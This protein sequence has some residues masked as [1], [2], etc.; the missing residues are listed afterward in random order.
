MSVGIQ[1]I[2]AILDTS[3]VIPQRPNT[4]PPPPFLGEITFEHVAFAYDPA[5][6]VLGDVGFA[7]PQ[8]NWSVSSGRPA[9]AKPL[10]H[11][12]SP[13]A[14][15]SGLQKRPIDGI[16]VRDYTLHGLRSQIG[17]VLQNTMLLRR[18]VRDNIAF[19]RVG[20]TEDE[21]VRAAELAN[22]HEFISRMP[23]GYDS[24]VKEAARSR[25]YPPAS[26]NASGLR[27]LSSATTRS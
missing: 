14:A 15:R 20:A 2:Q 7:F 5:R 1:R 21:I 10:S 22:A 8:G 23:Y 25:R 19:G 18:T 26:A 6:P 12:S 4:I 27:A 13:G 17:V 9:V 11:G 3:T 16:D 24:L